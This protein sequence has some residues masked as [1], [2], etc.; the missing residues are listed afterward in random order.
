MSG[1]ETLCL[2]SPDHHCHELRSSWRVVLRD[3]KE[4]KRQGGNMADID[5]EFA[6]FENEIA[7]LET[8]AVEVREAPPRPARALGRAGKWREGER[9]RSRAGD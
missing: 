3:G 4:G 1:A 5:A 7:E 2:Y 6:L 9:M 8:T